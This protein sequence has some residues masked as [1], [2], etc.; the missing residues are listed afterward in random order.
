MTE[1]PE[2]AF[3]RHFKNTKTMSRKQAEEICRAWECA[4]LSNAGRLP[5]ITAS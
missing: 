1:I 2:G 3:Q 5:E 4:A